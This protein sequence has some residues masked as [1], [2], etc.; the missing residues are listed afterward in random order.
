MD[1]ARYGTDGVSYLRE[2]SV[3]VSS[4]TGQGY[5]NGIAIPDFLN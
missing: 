3:T 1:M 5:F 4:D 2:I